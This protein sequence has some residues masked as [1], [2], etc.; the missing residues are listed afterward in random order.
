MEQFFI[1]D[2]HLGHRNIL[3]FA[4]P[5]F[6]DLESMFGYIREKWEQRVAPSDIV[7][8]LGDV[9]FGR[10]YEDQFACLPGRKKLIIG[11]HDHPRMYHLFEK[12]YGVYE[13]K[14]YVLSHIPVHPGQ[15]HRFR[16]NIHGH[17]HQTVLDNPWYHN[18]CVEQINYTPVTLEEID[19]Q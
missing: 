15:M 3:K 1:S 5:E 17:L 11:N 9:F 2:L 12:V 6:N 19:K 10:E 8:V 13:Y 16:G 7:W 18:V 4:R 14:N